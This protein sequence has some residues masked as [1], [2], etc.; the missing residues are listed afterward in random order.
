VSGHRRIPQRPRL[1]ARRSEVGYTET[2]MRA[3]PGEPEAVTADE[4]ETITRR[5]HA[6]ADARR[7][8]QAKAI[9]TGLGAAVDAIETIFGDAALEEVRA[10]RRELARIERKVSA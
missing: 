10:M 8:D 3:M 7:R 1:L 2:T 4:Q 6:D 5:A 9:L